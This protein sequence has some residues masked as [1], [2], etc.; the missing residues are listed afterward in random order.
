[1]N[2]KGTRKKL[3]TLLRSLDREYSRQKI[4]LDAA[5]A[6]VAWFNKHAIMFAEVTDCPMT[7]DHRFTVTYSRHEVG[8][9]DNSVLAR[10]LS[11]RIMRAITEA[12]K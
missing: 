1:M 3:L 10:G 6:K 4:R 11:N 7:A 8:K 9:I 2:F 5:E 12:H